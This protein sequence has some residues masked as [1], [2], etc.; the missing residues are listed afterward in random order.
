ME[1]L[2]FI[3]W[4]AVGAVIG[5]FAAIFF[6]WIA[7]RQQ[8]MQVIEGNIDVLQRLN[9]TALSNSQNL[10][11][12]FT[13]VISHEDAARKEGLYQGETTFEKEI[14]WD[15]EEAREI[16]FH[17]LRINRMYRAWLY[18]D[19]GIMSS[20]QYLQIV[21]NYAG[22]LKRAAKE[23]HLDRLAERGYDPR[24]ITEL[25]RRIR[26]ANEPKVLRRVI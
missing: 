14:I 4:A 12:A 15:E 21:G 5:A 22:T 24:F 8:R 25:E 1:I 13:S 6:G 17:F 3:D 10:E 18:H 23:Y 16:F 19:G 11:A 9:E 7:I 26:E 20:I 2:G